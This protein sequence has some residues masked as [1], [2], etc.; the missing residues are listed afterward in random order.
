MKNQQTINSD[1]TNTPSP[2]RKPGAQINQRAFLQ[3]VGILVALIL[4]AGALTYLAPAREYQRLTTGESGTTTTVIVP[5]SYHEI[6]RPDYPVWRWLSAPVEVLFAPGGSIILAIIIFILLVGAAFTVMERSG[7]LEYAIGRIVLAFG[8]RKYVLL[9]AITLFFMAL[10]GFFGIFEEMIPLV[11][12]M[13]ALAYSLGWDSLT[14]LGM[15]VLAT[16]VGFSAAVVNPFTLGVAH[17]LAGLPLFSGTGPRLA[18]FG[19]MYILLAI[20]LVRHARKVERQPQASPVFHED[21]AG[22]GHA[23]G[24]SA[25]AVAGL[26]SFE[27]S[28]PGMDRAALFLA[29]FL[30]LILVVLFA[31]AFVPL[32]S[33]LALPLTG[34]LFV[35]GGVGAAWIQSVGTPGASPGMARR[36]TLKAALDGFI[37]ILPA[38]PL[39]LLAASVR[40]IVVSAGVLDTLL[41]WASTAFTGAHPLAAVLW[42][43][44]LTLL[45]DLVV[46][47][48]SA[49][50]FLLIPFLMP[51]ADLVGV[52]RQ[53]AVSA[54]CFGDG[55]S[56]LAYPTSAALLIALSLTVVSYPKW[57]RWVLGLWVWVL[58]V[59]IVFLAL[60]VAIGYGPF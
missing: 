45:L 46:S 3:A 14:G 55:F 33:D 39:L 41:Y 40:H 6:E 28:K 58:L 8:A 52:T 60:A 34:V 9:L 44:G 32:L 12:I 50:A 48:G 17:K 49:K 51:L 25:A 47:S 19:V 1:P 7:I 20:F 22:R 5:G 18:L 4:A 27:R 10:G 59:T 23:P 54:F 31:S 16:N 30:G 37:G 56:N 35:T 15:S 38:V 11:P 57:L 36:L 29:V 43:Y 26:S 24:G 53:T 2:E 21:Q 42:V 13:V